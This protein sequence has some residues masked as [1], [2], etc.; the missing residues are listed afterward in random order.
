[1]IKGFIDKLTK[2]VAK[3]LE[4]VDTEISTA[5]AHLA[6]LL[7]QREKLAGLVGVKTTKARGR[8]VGHKVTGKRVNWQ[9]ALAAIPEKF[10]PQDFMKVPD[11]KA[12]GIAQVYPALDR[13]VK[14]KAI[15]KVGKGTYVKVA[16]KKAA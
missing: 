6:E 9:E 16:Q 5:E 7:A 2:E 12:R 14:A 11:V 13:L 15:R 3:A 10:V 8:R 4:G 1:M